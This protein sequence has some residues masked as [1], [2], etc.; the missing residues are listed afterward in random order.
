MVC[1]SAYHLPSY[2]QLPLGVV[3]SSG[4]VVYSSGIVVY[5]GGVGRRRREGLHVTSGNIASSITC[6]ATIM[7]DYLVSQYARNYCITDLTL[8]SYQHVGNNICSLQST[9]KYRNLCQLNIVC[10]M[11][12]LSQVPSDISFVVI[13]ILLLT[14]NLIRNLMV[15]RL[16]IR[17][18]DN[19]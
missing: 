7:L 8:V 12:Y 15:I 17:V 2:K 6:R 14:C 1:P 11:I 13:F 16:Q 10:Y 5:T 18:I 9:P 4:I 19:S 3:Y